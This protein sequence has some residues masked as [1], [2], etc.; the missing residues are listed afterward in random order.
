LNHRGLLAR[1][2]AKKKKVHT[3]V[4]PMTSNGQ[5]DSAALNSRKMVQK[6]YE[7]CFFE[8]SH[9]KVSGQESFSARNDKQKGVV[10]TQTCSGHY[11]PQRIRFARLGT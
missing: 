5:F 11:L 10:R 1:V 7:T 4:K 9:T 6:S 8:Q 2:P 3:N